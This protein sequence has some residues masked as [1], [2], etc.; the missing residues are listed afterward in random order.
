[1]TAVTAAHKTVLVA[2][3]TPAVCNRFVSALEQ[4]GHRAQVAGNATEVLARLS[5]DL[6]GI[7]LIVVDLRLPP[8]GGLDLVRAIRKTDEGRTPILVFSGTIGRARDV[9]ELAELG[10]VGYVNEFSPD[11]LIL[12]ALAP[13][14]F[15]DNFNRRGSPRVVMGIPVAYRY[16]NTIAAAVTLNLGKGGVAIRTMSP[17]D[18]AARARIRFRLP[19]SM[20]DV[21]AEARVSWTDRQVGIGLEFERIDIA[22]QRAINEFVDRQRDGESVVP[23]QSHAVGDDKQ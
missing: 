12:P 8:A 17:L 19:T 16:A 15:P 3:D 4:A 6:A 7:D 11:T 2:H 20:R 13:H 23:Q 14:L 21:D 1:M 10:I 22:D 5:A 9:R 18:P